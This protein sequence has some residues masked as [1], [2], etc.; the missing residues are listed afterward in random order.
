[1]KLFVLAKNGF[2]IKKQCGCGGENLITRIYKTRKNAE[3]YAAQFNADVY[4]VVIHDNYSTV[5]SVILSNVVDVEL[6]NLGLM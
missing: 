5:S 3:K 2:V 6:S 4:S 1:M